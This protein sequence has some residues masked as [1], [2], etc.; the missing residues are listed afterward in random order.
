MPYKIVNFGN[1]LYKVCKKDNSKCFSNQGLPLETAKKQL[2]AI[3]MSG[4]G[5][6]N[7]FNKYLEKIQINPNDYLEL[8][9]KVA[10]HRNY[11]P[12]LLEFANDGIHKLK[13]NDIPFG[14]IGYKDKIIYAWLEASEILPEGTTKKKS[15]NYRKRAK[16]VMKETNDKFSPASLSYYLI[17]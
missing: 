3:G 13:Y 1:N 4:K 7:N 2:K 5:K 14:R 15:T 9:K 16:K 11:N 6:Y 17:W 12:N 10:K 8:V